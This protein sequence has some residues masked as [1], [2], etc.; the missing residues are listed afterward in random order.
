MTHSTERNCC[1]WCDSKDD[2]IQGTT[3]DG[4]KLLVCKDGYSCGSRWGDVA[5]AGR[6][7]AYEGAAG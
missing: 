1:E 4:K 7:G 2:L 6:V 5:P 3:G